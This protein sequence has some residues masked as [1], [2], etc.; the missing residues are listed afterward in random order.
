MGQHQEQSFIDYKSVAWIVLGVTVL[1]FVMVMDAFAQ[2]HDPMNDKY[3]MD[4][5]AQFAEC[6][7]LNSPIAE[8]LCNCRTVEQQCEAA[9]HP[10]HGA[11]KTVEYW[12]SDDEADREVQ[13][14]LFMDYDILGGFDVLNTGLVMTCMQGVS[15]FNVFV[16]QF[17]DPESPPF[18]SIAGEKF[19]AKFLQHDEQWYVNMPK[20]K[21][22]YSALQN[23]RFM[24]VDFTDFEETAVSL[25]FETEGFTQVTL[26]WEKVCHGTSS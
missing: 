9:R 3:S 17:I 26:G 7:A 14:L 15:D 5:R 6:R 11:W 18:V 16:G 8:F 10:Q 1:V 13:F 24:T 23:A 12:P 19:E 25:E 4:A 2:D 20:T 21:A 22:V